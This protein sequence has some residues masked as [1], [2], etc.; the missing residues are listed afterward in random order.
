MSSEDRAEARLLPHAM[1][2]LTSAHR[3]L[4]SDSQSIAS[5]QCNTHHRCD[6]KLDHL[7]IASLKLVEH[8]NYHGLVVS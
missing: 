6:L 7:D 4:P 8:G 2:R 1:P 3:Q 5:H